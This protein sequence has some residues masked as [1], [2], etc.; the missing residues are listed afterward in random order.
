VALNL[1]SEAR[2]FLDL[3]DGALQP[4][5]SRLDFAFRECPIRMAPAANHDQL[6]AIARL[7]P[8]EAARGRHDS[9]RL[10]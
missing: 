6:A 7:P 3:S 2:F 5:F 1:D 9:Y 8:N 10:I 4:G